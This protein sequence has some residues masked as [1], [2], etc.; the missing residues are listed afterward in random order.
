MSAILKNKFVWVGGLGL[1]LGILGMHFLS[2]MSEPSGSRDLASTR[3]RLEKLPGLAQ[4]QSKHLSAISV[5]LE[6]PAKIP[7]DS[8]DQNVELYATVTLN[9][10]PSQDIDLEW[11]LPEDVKLILGNKTAK[12]TNAQPGQIYQVSIVVA[13]FDKTDKKVISLSASADR[14]GVRL[15][16]SSLVSSRPEDSLEFI[17]PSMAEAAA[18]I[19][20]APRMGR[21]IK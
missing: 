21:V 20:I 3:A 4:T 17:A 16:N 10:G 1:C 18:E 7:E 14:N 11:T 12:I 13:G 9:Q 6:A 2:G 15:G 19:D 5:R 8:Q